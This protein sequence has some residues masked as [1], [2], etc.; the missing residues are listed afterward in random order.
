MK[1]EHDT[2]KGN[3]LFYLPRPIKNKE[4]EKP[5]QLK[6]SK[7]KRN[8]RIQNCRDAFIILSPFGQPS[9]SH[10]SYRGGE[11]IQHV[12]SRLTGRRDCTCFIERNVKLQRGL[13]SFLY[14]SFQNKNTPRVIE[15][16]GEER[17][18]QGRRRQ[19]GLLPLAP[20]YVS[21]PSPLLS[22][23]RRNLSPSSLTSLP[24]LAFGL[25][26]ER[27][28]RNSFSNT[29]L[30]GVPHLYKWLCRHF[31]LF[32]KTLQ[33][34]IR[35]YIPPSSSSLVAE[36]EEERGKPSHDQRKDRKMIERDEKNPG[37]T[38][39]ERQGKY[40]PSAVQYDHPNSIS[41]SDS[42]IGPSSDSSE[43]SR[44]SIYD[45]GQHPC[46]VS[47]SSSTPRN[48]LPRYAAN[49]H[50]ASPVPSSST[51]SSPV[52]SSPTTTTSTTHSSSSLRLS[53]AADQAY[54]EELRR[55]VRKVATGRLGSE[56][57]SGRKSLHQ[58]LPVLPLR[59]ER[60][61][62][63]EVMPMTK[64]QRDVYVSV[65]QR[66]LQ[67]KEKEMLSREEGKRR[68]T[69][70][71]VTNKGKKKTKDE[72]DDGRDKEEGD[73]E[74]RHAE[75]SVS[76]DSQQSDLSGCTYGGVRN[77]ETQGNYEE[78]TLIRKKQQDEEEVSRD[79]RLSKQGRNLRS[80]SFSYSSLSA[81]SPSLPRSS[82]SPLRE[83]SPFPSLSSSSSSL[84][85]SSAVTTPPTTLPSPSSFSSVS[86]SSIRAHLP[87]D[88]LLLDFNAIIHLCTHG[89]LPSNLP[90]P[91]VIHQPQLLQRVCRY[92]HTLVSLVRPRKLLVITLDGVPPLAKV[93]Q[94]RSR[95]FRQSRDEQLAV[96]LEDEDDDEEAEEEKR[97]KGER[98]N[99]KRSTGGY[100]KDS[101][102]MRRN[103][104]ADIVSKSSAPLRSNLSS[105][106]SLS[107]FSSSPLSSQPSPCSSS[108]LS[109]S[110]SPVPES[111][112][113]LSPLH[114]N[115]YF[116]TNCISPGTTFMTLCELTLR[117]FITHKRRTSPL[118]RNLQCICLNPHTVPGEGEHKILHLLRYGIWPQ[119]HTLPRM[120]T[121]SFTDSE[122]KDRSSTS[123]TSSTGILRDQ[124]EEDNSYWETS[125]GPS[126][127]DEDNSDKELEDRVSYR[128]SPATQGPPLS[129][130]SPEEGGGKDRKE[131]ARDNK[132]KMI[133]VHPSP[134]LRA[135]HEA[136]LND[137]RAAK[138]DELEERR[139]RCMVG[140][141]LRRG[142]EY[143][144]LRD[145]ERK[146]KKRPQLQVLLPPERYDGG[147]LDEVNDR[148]GL[149]SLR[150]SKTPHTLGL[151]LSS[152]QYKRASEENPR[153]LGG[154]GLVGGGEAGRAEEKTRLDEAGGRDD[155]LLQ[156]CS[157]STSSPPSS[158]AFSPGLKEREKKNSGKPVFLSTYLKT[159]LGG[160]GRPSQHPPQKG[161]QD[162][163]E[164]RQGDSLCL[165]NKGEPQRTS[166][167]DKIIE[168]T[169]ETSLEQT[170]PSSSSLSPL[171]R[172]GSLLHTDT[173]LPSPST[174][175]STMSVFS[176]SSFS[177]PY[178]PD[179]TSSS[180]S[181]CKRCLSP[182]DRESVLPSPSS[183][184][185]TTPSE[186]NVPLPGYICLY[187][188]DADLL[189][190]TLSL[191]T[192]Q[193]LILREKQTSLERTRA[194][195]LDDVLAKVYINPS[196]A[197]QALLP[198][199]PLKTSSS[200]P[201]PPHESSSF[202]PLSSLSLPL[203]QESATD[204]NTPD[205]RNSS[206]SSTSSFLPLSQRTVDSSR[207]GL[208]H[209]KN[210]AAPTPNS[211]EREKELRGSDADGYEEKNGD[212][213]WSGDDM[214]GRK[215]QENLLSSS[216]LSSSPF[217]P[218]AK[219]SKC[220]LVI[221][222]TH[223]FLQYT[224]RD[225]E[226]VDV[227][228]LRDQLARQLE[229]SIHTS[230]EELSIHLENMKDTNNPKN[231]PVTSSLLSDRN[232]KKRSHLGYNTS[233]SGS[234]DTLRLTSSPRDHPMERKKTTQKFLSLLQPG[235]L[236]RTLENR[237]SLS[238][239]GEVNPLLSY[240]N[241]YSP[242]S[243][244]KRYFS[245][246]GETGER[247]RTGEDLLFSSLRS[248]RS[249]VRNLDR[250]RLIDD[251]I[252]LS[253]FVGNDFLPG[254][255]HVDIFQG[256]LALLLRTYTTA[257]PLLGGYL[258]KKTK[259]HL[260]RLRFFFHLLSQSEAEHFHQHLPLQALY[261]VVRAGQQEGRAAGEEK[262]ERMRRR[263][264]RTSKTSDDNDKDKEE[265]RMSLTDS[266]TT[267]ARKQDM[268]GEESYRDG[269]GGGKRIEDHKNGEIGEG[270]A[271]SKEAN[272]FL[273]PY[274]VLYYTS[275]FSLRTLL[276]IEEGK[277]E[278]EEGGEDTIHHRDSRISSSSFQ[279]SSS[280][281]LL[282]STT[283]TSSSSPSQLP[284]AA[285]SVL[286]SPPFETFRQKL[287]L[288]YLQGLFFLLRYYHTSQ[289][290]W[291]WHYAHHYA[292]LC[293][294]L[295][296]LSPQYISK[297][298][299]FL[300]SSSQENDFMLSP[301]L[302]L[303][304][305]LPST[306]ISL[307]PYLY[308]QITSTSP[309]LTSVT[310]T[311]DFSVDQYPFHA[312]PYHHS[313]IE[314]SQTSLL[315]HH[316]DYGEKEDL[317]LERSISREAPSLLSSS[318]S[319][320]SQYYHRKSSQNGSAMPY[321][322]QDHC[323]HQ[324]EE[325]IIQSA[326]Q[327]HADAQLI[328]ASISQAMMSSS[329]PPWLHRPIL[330]QLDISS[331]I[332][333]VQETQDYLGKQVHLLRQTAA[334]EI[335]GERRATSSVSSSL[336]AF[337]EYHSN[338]KDLFFS[339]KEREEKETRNEE[340]MKMWC[341]EDVGKIN[342]SCL[343]P[344]REA[345]SEKDQAI[346]GHAKEMMA[347]QK[348]ETSL[349]NDEIVKM[350]KE[351]EFP[352]KENKGDKKD[353]K[354]LPYTCQVSIT[355]NDHEN[356]HSSSC[357]E[358]PPS[359]L[360]G[361]EG[362]EANRRDREM[363][364]GKLS[365][366]EERQEP[367]LHIYDRR[368][369]DSVQ[370]SLSHDSLTT[371]QDIFRNRIG[372]SH[373]FLT[374][375]SPS[376]LSASSPK[377][378]EAYRLVSPRPPSST[379]ANR[380]KEENAQSPSMKTTGEDRKGASSSPS[381]LR[382]V[383]QQGRG[384][385]A[386]QRERGE[387]GKGRGR[388]GRRAQVLPQT[389]DTG[390]TMVTATTTSSQTDYH[391]Q[392]AVRATSPLSPIVKHGNAGNGEGADIDIVSSARHEDRAIRALKDEK[393][394]QTEEGQQSGKEQKSQGEASSLLRDGLY[395][396]GRKQKE[397]VER[398]EEDK[399][400]EGDRRRKN[401]SLSSSPRRR[402]ARS[403]RGRRTS[404]S[405]GAHLPDSTSGETSDGTH[406][407]SKQS[408]NTVETANSTAKTTT[409]KRSRFRGKAS[410]DT[411]AMKKNG[412][413][414]E[415]SEEKKI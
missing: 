116:D 236:H 194:Q 360:K 266:A 158:P 122:M 257:L 5:S 355:A 2:S 52:S 51:C 28:D 354:G 102:L 291:S 30:A 377:R 210:L 353:D 60:S 382:G 187:G 106:S 271:R 180:P 58:P 394:A 178:S 157:T 283:S 276:G 205:Q 413:R 206:S 285:S 324:T 268:Q 71:R 290:S 97:R 27:R 142:D 69:D 6:A 379:S 364:L 381:F 56:N 14:F 398:E 406:R 95:R 70:A 82:F 8:E 156:S 387:G 184:S 351:E 303:I 33:E 63:A 233:Y 37:E 254:L 304:S 140:Q 50:T 117:K 190:L 228:T 91:L 234:L 362:N 297:H 115:T 274:G 344:Q 264:R 153:S 404:P 163:V 293:S 144:A 129:S 54:K 182:K 386:R 147:A 15:R 109:S 162:V 395:K 262:I 200:P 32:R 55:L 339:E 218:S 66:V 48:S 120:I 246:E 240:V 229:E 391:R 325:K 400:K 42:P 242:D 239:R 143:Q 127:S 189:M 81:G 132:K 336:F 9:H 279:A 73:G 371:F 74:I 208:N 193:L 35:L 36:E 100:E 207:P 212:S 214:R 149:L 67:L 312:I 310:G 414:D 213:K 390:K 323:K 68:K 302:Q 250:S 201:S 337:H 204:T 174:S 138:N 316:N 173:T 307:L 209:S 227:D 231:K 141:G 352:T 378:R 367:L 244:R 169:K 343:S 77:E 349:N 267:T 139:R 57:R 298:L 135:T 111:P 3:L 341:K 211:Q 403:R 380:E 191:H 347:K 108:S 131:E 232:G 288:D 277:E 203:H 1:T 305:V 29:S 334:A 160:G 98:R 241:A 261:H 195:T 12:S 284:A 389:L 176:S 104:G 301:Y 113:S 225:F 265:G 338:K 148:E 40:S 177:G 251:F 168:K 90:P 330:P 235:Q 374:S 18:G 172:H 92:L 61:T 118:W 252:F 253:F 255:P 88:A 152:I 281:N 146:K 357:D 86:L 47:S 87:V 296:L 315:S 280:R 366:H 320:L 84:P 332:E 130:F 392:S 199:T 221:P 399:S 223:D 196:N 165:S 217:S 311:C 112:C 24:L 369:P 126:E 346:A 260:H 327:V 224:A 375:A 76:D 198:L 26:E 31:P 415:F 368:I 105:P 161:N 101:E 300:H 128:R 292:P 317:R 407:R 340:N 402:T 384:K 79:Y 333:A 150:G 350:R 289:P 308:R 183:P 197:R 49:T 202:S 329:L 287:S 21:S 137:P 401:S 17:V 154:V 313:S 226:V 275:K 328:A 125:T 319:L 171:H 155:D 19:R 215:F 230:E 38:A 94:Q 363:C 166:V 170:T 64:V 358:G 16:K 243:Q 393:K 259:I 318:L 114:L 93:N 295:S 188:M 263:G 136:L 110:S 43:R 282:S 39:S 72:E 409:S 408:D 22:W 75:T 396:E 365:P 331:V 405:N 345:K 272:L 273:P 376:S 46:L 151:S 53:A 335:G 247:D 167:A 123:T 220:E 249:F 23:G 256:G 258:T 121:S 65:M 314:G 385:R 164:S 179:V 412:Q 299:T 134:C 309:Y 216:S 96:R 59:N 159:K 4:G 348:R 62:T 25:R 10:H 124:G 342:P 388:Q 107:S 11:R 269:L 80:S 45:R 34:Y 278:Q 89:H 373:T 181:G 270:E 99:A 119:P 222:H 103:Q 370:D 186:W 237:Q 286:F 7:G 83:T 321:L 359:S 397:L 361:G 185:P 322:A 145:G 175:P 133:T 78:N 383:E 13:L 245:R 306:S 41:S 20:Q 44:I 410:T 372:I 294:D 85:S 411:Q 248:N 192:P 219:E 238:G 356:E 326:L